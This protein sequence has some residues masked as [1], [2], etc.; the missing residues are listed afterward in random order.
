[1]VEGFAESGRL[2]S[3]QFAE[4]ALQSLLF[5]EVRRSCAQTY[6]QKMGVELFHAK[7]D[8]RK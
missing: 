8:V 4:I 5:C 6:P 3:G 7:V 1:M 2:K